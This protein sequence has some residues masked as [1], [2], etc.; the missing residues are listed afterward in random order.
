MSSL[1]VVAGSRATWGRL[2]SVLR[3]LYQGS[4]LRPFAKVEKYIAFLDRLDRA[5]WQ[6]P[7][8][9]VASSLDC[10]T[11]RTVFDLGA[12]SGYFR[13]TKKPDLLPYHV[14]LVFRKGT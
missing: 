9:V 8:E 14:F 12:G 7:D 5:A 3:F 1:T 10:T 11:M 13:F 4:Q 2:R 6:G